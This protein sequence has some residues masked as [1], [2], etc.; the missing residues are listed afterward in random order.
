M[1][2]FDDN[3]VKTKQRCLKSYKKNLSLR[4]KHNAYFYFAN[5]FIWQTGAAIGKLVMNAAP[6]F[7]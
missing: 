5:T 1:S 3:L 4:H 2:D 7:I 6:T